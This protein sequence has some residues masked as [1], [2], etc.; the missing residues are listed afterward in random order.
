MQSR[1]FP[2][3]AICLS[4]LLTGCVTTG[5]MPQSTL[6]QGTASGPV[7]GA[8]GGATSVNA[9][10]ERCSKTLGTLAIDD[11]RTKTWMGSFT[12]ATQITTLEPMIRLLVQQSNCFMITTLGN[13]E[14]ETAVDAIKTR[15][16]SNDFRQG[17]NLGPNQRIVA[18]YYLQPAIFLSQAQ[19]GKDAV[20]VVGNIPI[21][22]QVL[23][24]VET[25]TSSVTLSLVDMRAGIQVAAAEGNSTS[26]NIGGSLGA[27]FS[28]GGGAASAYSRTPAGKATLAAFVDSYNQLVVAVKNYKP[29]TIDGGPGTAGALKVQGQ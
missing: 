2:A 17:S 12:K 19:T 13:R 10:V 22:G 24:T 14:I 21:L 20:R 18:D 6:T 16:G 7:T 26:T 27:L 1:F 5:L 11:G 28:A 9:G 4:S 8:A 3:T 15:Q 29:Q 23:G 25:Q